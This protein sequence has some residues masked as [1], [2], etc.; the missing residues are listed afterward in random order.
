M[1]NLTLTIAG[2]DLP[3]TE[4]AVKDRTDGRT[5]HFFG[6]ADNKAAMRFGY[7]IPALAESLPTSVTIDGQEFPLTLG[8]TSATTTKDVNGSKVK[9]EIPESERRQRA[10][11]TK[12]VTFPSIGEERDVEFS[13]S[14]TKGG[15][16]NVKAS[17]TRVGSTSVSP[18]DRAARAAKTADANLAALRALM[19]S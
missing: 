15:T 2:V 18:E 17:I 1:S 16:W 13:V 12:V 6:P 3:L 10:H 7:A 5:W 14:I 8:L 9:V 11:G 4:V 19:A